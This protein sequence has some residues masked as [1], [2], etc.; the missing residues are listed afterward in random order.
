MKILHSKQENTMAPGQLIIH[1]AGERK[2][3]EVAQQGFRERFFSPQRLQTAARE[4][5]SNTKTYKFEQL[6]PSI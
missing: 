1:L 5:D 3:L 2:S 6:F 4:T